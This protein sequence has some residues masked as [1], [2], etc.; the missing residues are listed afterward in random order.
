MFVSSHYTHDTY[1]F[2]TLL[3]NKYSLAYSTSTAVYIHGKRQT[4]SSPLAAVC[5]AMQYCIYSKAVYKKY[6]TQLGREEG[7]S[8]FRNSRAWGSIAVC[9]WFKKTVDTQKIATAVA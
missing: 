5:K 1:H 2:Y 3:N 4:G 6:C 8:D 9:T 7:N